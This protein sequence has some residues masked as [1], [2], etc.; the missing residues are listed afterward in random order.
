VH[1]GGPPL[2]G[3]QS[4]RP[5]P[6]DAHPRAFG[7]FQVR[8]TFGQGR[9]GPV[10][11]AVDPESNQQV[12]VRT[13]TQPLTPD[14]RGSL[15]E[16]LC[17]LC[18]LPLDHPSVA[19]PISC[20][21]E[22]DT[23]YFV[24]AYLDG[25]PADEYLASIGPS[26]LADLV[27]VIT[28]AAAALDFAAA[29]GVTHGALG[30][31]DVIFGTAAAGV[32]GFGLVQS[33][34]AAGVDTSGVVAQ[35]DAAGSATEAD[36]RALAMMTSQLLV[37]DDAAR[38]QHLIE[39]PPQTAL[40]L[41]AALHDV[42]ARAEPTQ[43]VD[44]PPAP[45]VTRDFDYQPRLRADEPLAAGAP[46]SGVPDLDLRPSTLAPSLA[47]TSEAT[48]FRPVVEPRTHRTWIPLAVAASLAIGLLGGYTAGV[49]VGRREARRAPTAAT[50]PPQPTATAGQIF[51]DQG[52]ARP[53]TPDP[54]FPVPGSEVPSSAVQDSRVPGSAGTAN[55]ERG[56]ANRERA[57]GNRERGRG[58]E[59]RVR[60]LP[61]SLWVESRP[62]GA[63]VY[64]DGQLVG[65]TPLLLGG[66]AAGG[67]S[68]RLEMGGYQQWITRVNVAENGRTRVAASLEQQ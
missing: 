56:T 25:I 41:V 52:V 8:A 9:F 17:A 53:V 28:P 7:S 21:L 44:S 66:I 23:P 54:R 12:I 40:G 26:R 31:R 48:T 22:G 45:P 19:R 15:L 29:A 24:H 6:L 16:S 58:N 47:A 61:P 30:V 11:L 68:V 2:T 35:S 64:V 37:R 3:E 32:S 57:T 5:L 42:I 49:V 43:T 33:L 38:I 62:T 36:I 1:G 39:H 14:Q 59:E 63:T 10:F 20:G 4:I 65:R 55:R 67:H 46:T 34:A 50:V 18:E 27:P 13:F 60:V 51:T